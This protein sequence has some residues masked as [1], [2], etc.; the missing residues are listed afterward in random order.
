[1]EAG[2]TDSV[3][4]EPDETSRVEW[5]QLWIAVCRWRWSSLAVVPA[6]PTDWSLRV[7]RSLMRVGSIHLG[8]P[9][10]LMDACDVAS[11]AVSTFTT[12]LDDARQ[13]P[14]SL[15]LACPS[16]AQNEAAI[17]IIL[18]ADAVL[19]AVVLDESSFKSTSQILKLFGPRIIGSVTL[20]KRQ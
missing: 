16:P 6:S 17:P 20:P 2:V 5:H 11:N 1:M 18:A 15:I 9:V 19:L 13:T 8:G 14:R 10:Q 12:Y 3:G 7:A 4:L